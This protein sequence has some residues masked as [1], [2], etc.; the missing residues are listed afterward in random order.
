MVEKFTYRRLEMS[1]VLFQ[2]WERTRITLSMKDRTSTYSFCFYPFPN[3]GNVGKKSK[4]KL[5]KHYLFKEYRGGYCLYTHHSWSY[6]QRPN[7]TN[8]AYHIGNKIGNE[9]YRKTRFLE[10][11]KNFTKKFLEK[12]F[13]TN[14][15]DPN[16]IPF[17]HYDNLIYTLPMI[18]L[19]SAVLEG[20][21]REILAKYLQEEINKHIEIGNR[22]GRYKHNNYQKMLVAKQSLIES[23]STLG[24]LASEYSILFEFSASKVMP[25]Y[26]INIITSLSTLRNMVA[27]GTSIV[28]TNVDVQEDPYYKSWNDRVKKLQII[29]KKYFDSNDIYL[30]LSD[31]RLPDFYMAC[32]LHY[33]EYVVNYLKDYDE[34]MSKAI[35]QVSMM[36][37]INNISE[38]KNK[39]SKEYLLWFE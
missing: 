25:S 37:Y 17:K 32:V 6:N 28:T 35:K 4:G 3:S 2:S 8:T 30:N 33:L 21:L 19:S 31:S 36:D 9:I 5:I 38:I 13:F 18:S 11:I 12:E 14:K 10:N 22:T 1:K 34:S 27:H 16:K 39:Y 7:L 23:C 26:L 29:L 20:T 15:P 24:Q